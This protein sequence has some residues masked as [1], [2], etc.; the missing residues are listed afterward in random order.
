[1][2]SHHQTLRDRQVGG[3]FWEPAIKAA[4]LIPFVSLDW[5]NTK[6]QSHCA[7]IILHTTW[8]G[9]CHWLKTAKH[10]HIELW[11]RSYME[12]SRLRQS[13]A[14]CYIKRSQG[15]WPTWMGCD[16]TSVGSKRCKTQTSNPKPNIL[17]DHWLQ[18]HQFCKAPNTRCTSAV[19]PWA[20]GCQSQRN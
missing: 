4:V 17:T 10:T 18:K 5:E 15:Q 1:M 6:P 2:V 19:P 12:G 16:D 3:H 20:Y 13:R 11:R 9:R 14:R 7:W 8:S